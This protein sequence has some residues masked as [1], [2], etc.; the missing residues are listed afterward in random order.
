[1]PSPV[2]AQV[3]TATQT[4]TAGESTVAVNATPT[5]TMA[6]PARM[7]CRSPPTGMRCA[8]IHEP[9]VHDKV[10][11]VRTRPAWAAST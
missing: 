9:A 1:M 3:G 5:S 6:K 11:E 7:N 8:W 2:I 10:A 4:G